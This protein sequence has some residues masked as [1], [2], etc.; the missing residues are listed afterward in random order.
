MS[1][2]THVNKQKCVYH[3]NLEKKERLHGTK[4]TEAK[5]LPWVS[6]MLPLHVLFYLN[7]S[8]DIR[9]LLPNGCHLPPI[10]PCGLP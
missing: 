9:T 5:L 8:L 1:L 2:S 10:K 6:W 3:V 4:P 7:S